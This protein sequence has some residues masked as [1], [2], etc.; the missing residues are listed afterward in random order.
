[1]TN[2]AQMARFGG[3]DGAMWAQMGPRR[4]LGAGP[5]GVGAGEPDQLGRQKNY[6]DDD[7]RRADARDREP[8]DQDD[9]QDHAALYPVRDEQADHLSQ[10]G[11]EEVDHA[12]AGRRISVIARRDARK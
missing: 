8:G 11:P 7:S 3:G 9:R 4:L 1:M 10:R 12:R 5:A 2:W 6:E